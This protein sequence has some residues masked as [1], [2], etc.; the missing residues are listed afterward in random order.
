VDASTQAEAVGFDGHKNGR[1]RH[2]LVDTLGLIVRVTM[3]P[4]DGKKH[5]LAGV[6]TGRKERRP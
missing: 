6:Q 1:K 2:R 3:T 5:A 4:N